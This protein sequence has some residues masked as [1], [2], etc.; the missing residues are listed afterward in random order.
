MGTWGIRSDLVEKPRVR[1]ETENFL[2]EKLMIAAWQ[3]QA[4]QIRIT[5]VYADR[6][7]GKGQ[8]ETWRFN[9]NN[10]WVWSRYKC[11]LSTFGNN[12]P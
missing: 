1:V 7:G 4:S 9:N 11:P 8:D 10:I 2:P 3:M 12:K 5:L 6:F